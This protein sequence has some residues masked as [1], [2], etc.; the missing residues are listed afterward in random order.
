ME[1]NGMNPWVQIALMD[2]RPEI[3]VISLNI[4]ICEIEL[5]KC[6]NMDVISIAMSGYNLKTK[7]FN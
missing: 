7:I 1:K 6:F 5:Y 2:Q 3:K 4:Q